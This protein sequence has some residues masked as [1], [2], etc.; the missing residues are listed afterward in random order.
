MNVDG[1]N[2]RRLT[3]M[4]LRNSAQSVGQFRLAGSISFVSDTEFF[5]DVLTQSLGLAGKLVR[6]ACR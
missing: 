6:V 4:K 3:S 2:K 5:G 1:T